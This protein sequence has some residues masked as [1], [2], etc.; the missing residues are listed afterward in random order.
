MGAAGLRLHSNTIP[1]MIETS[2]SLSL[3]NCATRFFN[4]E[5]GPV[6]ALARLLLSE[7]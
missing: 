5:A 4:Q 3:I 6:E 2:S 7:T 1:V